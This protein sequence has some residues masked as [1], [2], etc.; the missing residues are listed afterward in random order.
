MQSTKRAG[1]KHHQTAQ[2]ASRGQTVSLGRGCPG[3]S[4]CAGGGDDLGGMVGPAPEAGVRGRGGGGGRD[5]VRL[6]ERGSLNSGLATWV[7]KA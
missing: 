7:A 3:L 1:G 4:L 6:T 5:P 2:G